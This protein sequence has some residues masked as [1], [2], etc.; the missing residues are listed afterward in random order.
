MTTTKKIEIISSSVKPQVVI[1]ELENLKK[2]IEE[3]FD[4]SINPICFNK[5]YISLK[6]YF[7]KITKAYIEEKGIYIEG[8]Q[9]YK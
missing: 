6:D 4:F 1:K 9:L 2:A 5:E 3:S 8:Q 7:L